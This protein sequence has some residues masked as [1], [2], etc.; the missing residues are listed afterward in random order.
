MVRAGEA[1]GL[2]V[3][4]EAYADR[5]YDDVGRLTSRQVEGALITDADVAV[6]QVLSFIDAGGIVTRGGRTI[7]TPIDTICAHGDESSG[8]AVMTAVRRALEARGIGIVTLPEV[9]R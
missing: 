3:A 8:V 4:H 1:E 2:R 7:R 5:T 6:R 9:K